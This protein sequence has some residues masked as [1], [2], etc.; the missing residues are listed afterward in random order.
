INGQGVEALVFEG[1]KGIQERLGQHLRSLY[2]AEQQ[3]I[4]G[5]MLRSTLAGQDEDFRM[6]NSLLNRVS[7]FKLLLQA[8]LMLFY[9]ETMLDSDDV[10]AMLAGQSGLLDENLIRRFRSGNAAISEIHQAGMARLDRFQALWKQQPE[11]VV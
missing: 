6:L 10:R 7:T 4:Y 11:S 3:A 8:Q 5:G 1:D 2:Q 9:P